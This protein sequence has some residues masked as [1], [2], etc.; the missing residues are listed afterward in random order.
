MKMLIGY[1]FQEEAVCG[2][3]HDYVSVVSDDETIVF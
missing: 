1:F 2:N 3:R